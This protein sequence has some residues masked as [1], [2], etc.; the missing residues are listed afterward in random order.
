MG[1]WFERFIWL[2][3]GLILV[4][5]AAASAATGSFSP[6]C[7]YNT[8]KSDDIYPMFL[9][10]YWGGVDVDTEDGLSTISE[11]T[12]WKNI[13]ITP[14][15]WKY[16]VIDS[17]IANTET[18]TI[19]LQACDGEWNTLASQEFELTG[20]KEIF[21]YELPKCENL[22]LRI[23]NQQGAKFCLRKMQFRKKLVLINKKRAVFA[24]ALAF[25]LYAGISLGA[26]ILKKKK[27]IDVLAP[28]KKVGYQCFVYYIRFIECIADGIYT[29]A[30]KWI[31]KRKKS[32]LS[33]IRIFVFAVWLLAEIFLLGFGMRS[34]VIPFHYLAAVITLAVF[35]LTSLEEHP[36]KLQWNNKLVYSWVSFSAVMVLSGL[37]VCKKWPGIGLLFLTIYAIWFFIWGNQEHPCLILK[38][39]AVSL[40]IVFWFT[41]VLS[42]FGRA[43]D[44]AL[45]YGGIYRNQNAFA[46]FLVLLLAVEF[47]QLCHLF[48]GTQYPLIRGLWMSGELCLMLFFMY[49]TQSRGGNFAGMVLLL[50]FVIH[51]FVKDRFMRGKKLLFL[52]QTAALLFP[53]SWGIESMMLSVQ[54][55]FPARIEYTIAEEEEK[56]I[57]EDSY[58]GGELVAAADTNPVFSNINLKLDI[59]SNGR[60][61]IW[62]TYI[63][64]FNL[65]GHRYREQINGSYMHPHNSLIHMAYLYGIF[66][67]VPY[68]AMWYMIFLCGIQYARRREAYSFFPVALAGGFFCMAFI[69]TLEGPFAI[70]IWIV[71]YLVIGVLFNTG[72]EKY[73]DTTV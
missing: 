23:Y 15:T 41:A 68:C 31:T 38:D 58:A 62:E 67:L 44:V 51:L 72:G 40:K 39:M 60:V 16:V 43:Y 10:L 50:L 53:V 73:E 20:G 18:L 1:R 3:C 66:A 56:P 14:K 30:G 61:A 70:E 5:I 45:P 11:D 7:F 47:A 65:W 59:W 12:A 57:F 54:A 22:A 17:S 29:I 35:I 52:A 6:D 24:G 21:S 63:R 4:Y 34:K 71:V 37:I 28:A 13:Q 64:N 48:S 2:V 46:A 25:V 36:D 33:I 42:V 27:K 49:R 9:Q 26:V 8:G 19:S 55:V 69:D 32:V